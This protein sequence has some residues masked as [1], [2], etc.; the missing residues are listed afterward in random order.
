MKMK[1]SMW[2]SSSEGLV[3]GALAMSAIAST[4]NERPKIR[5]M[6]VSIRDL[7]LRS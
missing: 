6:K 2:P 7:G 4:D 3:G 1:A 5:S